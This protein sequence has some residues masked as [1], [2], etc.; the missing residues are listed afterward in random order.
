MIYCHGFVWTG[1]IGGVKPEPKM[2]PVPSLT[3]PFHL[4]LFAK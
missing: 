2:P 3:C 1:S 4:L